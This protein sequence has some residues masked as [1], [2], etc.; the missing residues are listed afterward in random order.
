MVFLAFLAPPS[1]EFRV[2]CAST[3]GFV[4][5]RHAIPP[6]VSGKLPLRRRCVLRAGSWKSCVVRVSLRFFSDD[7]LRCSVVLTW[8]TCEVC[9]AGDLV[10]ASQFILP[11]SR[12][13]HISVFEAGSRV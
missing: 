5:S 3:S 12:T 10:P 8:W 4:V 1:E 6:C 11:I 9:N 7:D 2:A 13:K